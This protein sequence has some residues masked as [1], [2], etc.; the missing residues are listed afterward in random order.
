MRR[1]TVF[2]F[3]SLVLSTAASAQTDS[4][5]N[6]S[7]GSQGLFGGAH[8]SA[9]GTGFSNSDTSLGTALG[10]GV[11]FRLAKPIGWRGRAI[12]C[13]RDISAVRRTTFGFRLALWSGFEER[14][15]YGCAQYKFR[16]GATEGE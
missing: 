12:T 7:F 1:L 16:P 10:G 2:G 6:T 4:K 13:R 11:D 9:S 15:Y 3:V 8:T 14:V 5:G